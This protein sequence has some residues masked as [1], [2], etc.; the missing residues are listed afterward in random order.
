MRIVRVL[1][2][3]RRMLMRQLRMLVAFFVVALLVVFR[4]RVMCLGGV[5]V[6]LGCFAMCFVCHTAPLVLGMIPGGEIPPLTGLLTAQADEIAKKSTGSTSRLP[7]DC[8]PKTQF[9]P[10]RVLDLKVEIGVHPRSEGHRIWAIYSG[11][12]RPKCASLPGRGIAG[13]VPQAPK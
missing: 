6:M 12:N 1:V 9:K 3:L 8:E 11:G 5:F 4:C 10:E 7:R 13:S 2:S